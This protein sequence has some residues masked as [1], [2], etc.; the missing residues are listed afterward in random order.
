M[1]ALCD[2]LRL[3]E[4]PVIAPDEIEIVILVT[5]VAFDLRPV[6]APNGIEIVVL[7]AD[8]VVVLVL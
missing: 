6:I 3:P 2:I 1:W 4:Q 8:G 7:I 5:W